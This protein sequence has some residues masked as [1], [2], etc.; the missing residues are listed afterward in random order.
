MKKFIGVLAFIIMFMFSSCSSD[1]DSALADCSAVSC[2]SGNII[3]QFL[4]AETGEDVFFNDTYSFDELTI[5]DVSNDADF[6]FV[7]GISDDSQIAQVVLNAFSE[8]RSNV[9]LRLT[10]PDGFET[11]LSFDVE[12]KEGECCNINDYS[13]VQFSNVVNVVQ[14]QGGFFYNV[15]L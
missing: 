6:P 5:T 1:A 15:Y 7:T 12:Y 8:S 13:D 3:I 11:D 4:D 9:M 14:S 2:A 10:V